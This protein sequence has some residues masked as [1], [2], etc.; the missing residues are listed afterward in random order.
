MLRDKIYLKKKLENDIKYK[1]DRIDLLRTK[2]P[3]P[4]FDKDKVQGN[5]PNDKML[6]VIIKIQEMEEDVRF[7]R[8]ELDVLNPRIEEELKIIGEF[9]PL[10]KKIIELRELHKMTWEKIAEATNYSRRQCINIY[11]K[12]FR[13]KK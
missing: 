6:D 2:I 4:K 7:I 3:S 12:K 11:N 9:E 5:H 10:T 8:M 1:L 13:Y